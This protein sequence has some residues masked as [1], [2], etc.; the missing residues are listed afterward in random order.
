[1][2]RIPHASLPLLG[3]WLAACQPQP[4]S[5][6][7]RF[8]IQDAVPTLAGLNLGTALP[9]GATS[10]LPAGAIKGLQGAQMGAAGGAMG[11]QMGLE[12][13]QLGTWGASLTPAA[14]NLISGN[15]V[16]PPRGTAAD[17]DL[18][19]LELGS[20]FHLS[21]GGE[22]GIVK[23]AAAALALA[24]HPRLGSAPSCTS[25]GLCSRAASWNGPGSSSG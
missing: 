19:N 9:T 21:V 7:S 24:R 11:G 15:G 25:G 18:T 4:A 10:G 2:R 22:C 5:P 20:T 16:V 23:D 17:T 3:L 8:E 1:M 13:A 12:G 14:R 6:A